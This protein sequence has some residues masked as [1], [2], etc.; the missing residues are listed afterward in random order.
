MKIVVMRNWD[1]PEE[2]LRGARHLMAQ[3]QRLASPA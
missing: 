2:R 3:L 1:K